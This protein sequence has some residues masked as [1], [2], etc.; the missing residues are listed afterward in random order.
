MSLSSSGL[1]MGLSNRYVKVVPIL[2][3]LLW[4]RYPHEICGLAQHHEGAFVVDESL[5]RVSVKA[6]RTR[7]MGEKVK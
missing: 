5:Q 4:W 6:D 3:A 1:V 2:A 7:W